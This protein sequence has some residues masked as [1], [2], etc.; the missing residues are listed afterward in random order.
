MADLSWFW[1]AIGAMLL[2]G[3]MNFL[4]KVSAENKYDSFAILNISAVTVALLSAVNTIRHSHVLGEWQGALL[5]ALINGCF[6]M[7][8][9]VSK[10]SSLKYA[11]ANV[12]FPLTKLS[13]PLII[14]YSVLFLGEK[15]GSSQFLG[16][17]LILFVFYILSRHRE[18][19]QHF[20][21]KTKGIIL[22]LLSA[23]CVSISVTAGK[24]A[25]MYKVNKLI[26]MFYSYSI[27]TIGT[28]LLLKVRGKS[29][30]WHDRRAVRI[31]ISVGLLNFLGY[32][33]VLNAFSKGN[34][35]LVHPIFSLSIIIP[36]VLSLIIYHERLTFNKVLALVLTII[37]INLIRQG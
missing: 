1:L 4:L 14:L 3:V 30:L 15:I 9:S 8:G 31:G 36:I 11:P 10:I 34:L 13:M 2:Y 18:E 27:V 32:Y 26:Y 25:M 6:F 17:I 12:I 28:A 35:S 29:F 5:F 24:V 37:A 7:L 33:V 23:F 22:V 16:I 21:T 20:H 19:K